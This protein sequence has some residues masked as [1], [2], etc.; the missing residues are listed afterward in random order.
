MIDIL[1]ELNKY[2]DQITEIENEENLFNSSLNKSLENLVQN[3]GKNE[4]TI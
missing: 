2:I 3:M 4:E 1:L